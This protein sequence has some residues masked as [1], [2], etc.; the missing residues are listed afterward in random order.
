MTCTLK[1]HP[2]FGSGC[3]WTAVPMNSRHEHRHSCIQGW[4]FLGHINVNNLT[5]RRSCHRTSSCQSTANLRKWTKEFALEN[6]VSERSLN[7][8][9]HWIHSQGPWAKTTASPAC[10]AGDSRTA[11]CSCGL[12]LTAS[13]PEPLKQALH[14][15]LPLPQCQRMPLLISS[16]VPQLVSSTGVGGGT[17]LTMPAPLCPSFLPS[18]C[19]LLVSHETF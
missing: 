1:T 11:S 19:F 5:V 14:I 4:K 16:T 6:S 8:L 17:C 13:E 9:L 2:F 12:P 18:V 3:L 7:T 15:L 10:M